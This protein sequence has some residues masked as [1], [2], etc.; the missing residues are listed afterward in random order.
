MGLIFVANSP[1]DPLFQEKARRYGT[2]TVSVISTWKWYQE[3][4]YFV[5][6]IVKDRTI[7]TYENMP[8]SLSDTRKTN[9]N[10]LKMGVRRS[11]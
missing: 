9:R 3:V 8:L 1:I 5:P 2:H 7:L 10:M 11:R 4:H 6:Y